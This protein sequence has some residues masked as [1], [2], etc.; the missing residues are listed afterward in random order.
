VTDQTW[1]RTSATGPRGKLLVYLGAA[2]G[3]GKTY[4][5]LAGLLT[6]LR[7]LQ[8]LPAGRVARSPAGVPPALSADS[9]AGQVEIQITDQGV[10]RSNR[11]DGRH[12]TLRGE[13]GRG[14]TVIITLPAAASV[15]GA[16][17]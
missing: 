15:S 10:P 14:R 7:D 8:R 12:T 5:M 4:A 17:R 1:L 6:D 9:H 3:V 2:P 11:G 13:R 16:R